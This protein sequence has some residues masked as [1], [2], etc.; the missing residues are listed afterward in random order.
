ML[1]DIIKG[2]CS[3]YANHPS[4][5]TKDREYSF[6]EMNDMAG[7]VSSF[8]RMAG[9]RR[10]DMVVILWDNS[11]EYAALF[12][13]VLALG[14]TV[15]PLNPTNTMESVRFVAGNCGARFV[16]ATER[17][18]PYVTP[19]WDGPPIVSDVAGRD[20]IV[21][22]RDIYN[23]NPG[24]IEGLEKGCPDDLALVLYTS[25]TTGNPKGVMLTHRN[26][27]ANTDSILRY[28]GLGSSDR[29]LVVLPF[30]YSYG[31]SLLLTH[32]QTGA[33]L[34]VEN[35]FAF[36]NKCLD[37]MRTQKVTGFSGVPSH[38]SILL[39]R[40]IFLKSEWPDLRYMTCAGG[41]LSPAYIRKLREYLPKVQL[42]IMYGQTEGSAR[43]SSL[44]PTLV[45][46]KTG[47]IGNGI[48]GVILRVVDKEGIDIR[49]GEIGE[50]I[51]SG[52]NIMAGYLGDPETSRET[53]REGWLHTGDLATV[54]EEGYVY[55]KGRAKEF[56]KIGGYRISPMQIEEVL[57]QHPS[58]L[59]CAVVG[60][61]GDEF[62]EERVGAVI[63]FR[64]GILENEAAA[65]EAVMNFAREK[66]P[67]YMVPS[68]F[69]PIDSI[70][71]TESGKVRRVLLRE[72]ANGLTPPCAPL[73]GTR[74]SALSGGRSEP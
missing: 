10:G 29:T 16:A 74:P 25:G 28:L 59:E 58:V 57:L 13:G 2:A 12:F 47:S 18:L 48:P 42:H 19:W 67:L 73:Q 31:N 36:V 62:I 54:D 37:T 11:P 53:V 52:A 35:G 32:F 33:C 22:T 71:K 51:A 1:Q 5:I 45:D 27:E 39:N 66:L 63:V 23:M 14:G 24:G 41:G 56:I 7:S 60:I 8:F 15:V 21:F 38:Y 44:D 70:P 34:V 50:I 61:A 43:L 30:Y 72:W 49:A 40:S 69:F 17:S 55:I 68:R 3:R 26:L 20:G 4:I 9:L 6:Q 64:E 65:V 46:K